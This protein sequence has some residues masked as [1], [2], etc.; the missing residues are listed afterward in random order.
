[1]RLLCTSSMMNVA[2]THLIP[3]LKVNDDQLKV[4]VALALLH[5]LTPESFAAVKALVAG[6]SNAE[7][8]KF[9]QQRI[10]FCGARPPQRF[11]FDVQSRSGEALV[12]TEK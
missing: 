3:V 5:L 1:M 2:V 6:A 11:Q 12:K 4:E 9:I 10:T 7:V 8:K